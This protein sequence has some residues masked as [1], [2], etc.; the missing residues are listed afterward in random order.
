MMTP[1]DAPI[2]RSAIDHLRTH[3]KARST[4]HL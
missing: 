4:A 1:S 2:W 3:T